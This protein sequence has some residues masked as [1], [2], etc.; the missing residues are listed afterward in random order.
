MIGDRASVIRI[1]HHKTRS[2]NGA[3]ASISQFSMHLCPAAAVWID[4]ADVSLETQDIRWLVE[5]LGRN[6][7]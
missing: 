7:G 1:S 2:T 4:R 6:E 5:M 3:T